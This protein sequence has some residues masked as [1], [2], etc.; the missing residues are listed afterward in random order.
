MKNFFLDNVLWRS[1]EKNCLKTFFLRSPEN[2]FE[3][4]FFWR[5]LAFVSLVLGLGLEHSYPWPREVLSSEG[6]PLALVSDFFCVL[7]LGLELCV[8]DSISVYFTQSFKLLFIKQR[9]LSR[10]VIIKK[11]QRGAF[12]KYFISLQSASTF[13]LSVILIEGLNV[14]DSSQSL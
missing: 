13:Y 12:A 11:F 9:L 3:D 10:K 5:S 8:L 6:L 2:I 1:P 14:S 7:S 4:L